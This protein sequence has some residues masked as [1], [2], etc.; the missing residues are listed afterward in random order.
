[1]SMDGCAKKKPLTP[2]LTNMEMNPSANSDAALMR[3]FAP[4]RL[5]NHISVMIVAGIVIVSVGKENNKEENGFIPLTN[6]WC[7]QTI[8]LRKPMDIIEQLITRALKS[9]LRMLLIR[10]CETMPLE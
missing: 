4:Y 5:P 1:M 7:P 6:M 10:M 8:Q 2:P 3:M 9:G